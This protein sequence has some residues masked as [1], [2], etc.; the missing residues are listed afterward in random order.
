TSVTDIRRQ[1]ALMDLVTR[2]CQQAGVGCGA[3]VPRFV[4]HPEPANIASEITLS[5][6]ATQVKMQFEAADGN[7][8]LWPLIP[9]LTALVAVLIPL[10]LRPRIEEYR[11]RP[12]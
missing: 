4:P 5:D 3:T 8:G 6:R 2:E 1:Q 11:Y 7:G 12:R 10:G 9:L